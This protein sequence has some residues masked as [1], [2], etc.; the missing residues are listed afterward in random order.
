MA[1]FITNYL[2]QKAP[3]ITNYLAQ[4]AP[5]MLW[6]TISSDGFI[7]FA[8]GAVG[9]MIGHR[10]L[11]WYVPSVVPK[12]A[13]AYLAVRIART[14][15]QDDSCQQLLTRIQKQTENGLTT[16][17]EQGGKSLMTLIKQSEQS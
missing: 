3:Q 17:I 10:V 11:P 1:S 5:Q 8:G 15:R 7:G 13:G 4:R 12:I 2:T 6:N 14:I 9:R 16:L